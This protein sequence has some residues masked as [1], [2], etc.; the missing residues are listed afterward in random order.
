MVF[1]RI[2]WAFDDRYPHPLRFTSFTSQTVLHEADGDYEDGLLVSGSHLPG[3][4]CI[5]FSF[6]PPDPEDKWS[7]P[8][9]Q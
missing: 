3:G 8:V 4:F 7:E 2:Y 9:D 6:N 1:T 5:L